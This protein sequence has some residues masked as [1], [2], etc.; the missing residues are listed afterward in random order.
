M[1]ILSQIKH[2]F[3]EKSESCLLEVQVVTGVVFKGTLG[4]TDKKSI[5]LFLDIQDDVK[6]VYINKAHI[7]SVQAVLL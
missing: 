7:V 2:D 5:T 3:E 1:S 4:V 6:V